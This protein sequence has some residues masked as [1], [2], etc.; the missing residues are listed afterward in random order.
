MDPSIKDYFEK[1]I[2]RMEAFRVKLRNNTD[3]IRSNNAKLDGMNVTTLQQERA[4]LRCRLVRKDSIRL[5]HPLPQPHWILPSSSIAN[6]RPW[7]SP[8][9]RPSAWS[10]GC[11]DK[12]IGSATPKTTI[13]TLAVLLDTCSPA[14]RTHKFVKVL[15][16]GSPDCIVIAPMI[17]WTEFSYQVGAKSLPP[18]V[19]TAL[20][21][22]TDT[23]ALDAGL[24]YPATNDVAAR[25]PFADHDMDVLPRTRHQ[26]LM[27]R[28][29]ARPSF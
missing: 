6:S 14:R 29:T 7:R 17:C 15:C 20:L 21:L 24:V 26:G 11:D 9:H 25:Q 16:D 23:C 13:T 8:H 12:F 2:S 10:S 1:L 18:S 5:L 3:A 22:P 27:L 4:P 19:T 28:P